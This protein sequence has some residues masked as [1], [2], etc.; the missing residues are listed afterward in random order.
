MF[1]HIK[2]YFW[3]KIVSDTGT[4]SL[5]QENSLIEEGTK[6]SEDR[7]DRTTFGKITRQASAWLSRPIF[8]DGIS[9]ND[10]ENRPRAASAPSFGGMW[11]NRGRDR[12]RQRRGAI[13]PNTF[14]NL[15]YILGNDLDLLP[16]DSKLDLIDCINKSV[17]YLSLTKNE[18]LNI[19][20]EFKNLISQKNSILIVCLQ[21]RDLLRQRIHMKLGEI[22]KLKL[23]KLG[24]KKK[25]ALSVQCSSD[26]CIRDKFSIFGSDSDEDD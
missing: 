1:Q 6:I 17:N 10:S 20:L 8:Q 16:I 12:S 24:P 22:Q 23:E 9:G 26:L 3:S 18:L 21:E 4:Q 5:S 14:E 2:S 25:I 13:Q 11:K 19:K 7:R 15:D